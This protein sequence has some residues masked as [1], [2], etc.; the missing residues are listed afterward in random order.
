[1]KSAMTPNSI[2]IITW[3][4]FSLFWNNI[5]LRESRHFTPEHRVSEATQSERMTHVDHRDIIR[6]V[7]ITRLRLHQFTLELSSG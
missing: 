3:Y 4:E 6:D 2:F 1:M 5:S 7:T